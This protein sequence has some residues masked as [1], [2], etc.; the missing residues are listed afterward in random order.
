MSELF[1]ERPF[2]A[3]SLTGIR[4]FKIDR[5]GRLR[6]T[7]INVVWTPGENLARCM[8]DQFNTGGAF[9][10]FLSLSIPKL[11]YKVDPLNGWITPVTENE[12]PKEEEPKPKT[13]DHR[14]ATL[15]CTCGFYAFFDNDEN[16]WHQP[17]QIKG[18]IEGY[19]LTTVGTRGFRCE[20][21]KIRA[22]ILPDRRRTT[23]TDAVQRNYPDVPVFTSRRL[24]FAEFPLT[25]PDR[26]SPETDDDFWTRE[27]L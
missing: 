15:G 6:A 25:L 26:P 4:S 10:S 19:G 18:L 12:K 24:A 23:A 8:K 9:A 5:F 3:G 1:S 21:A 11:T 17:G 2:V 7:Q 20:K 14:V 13:V 22:L 27:A 16:Q